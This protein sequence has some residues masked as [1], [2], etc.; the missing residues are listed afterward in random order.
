MRSKL[1]SVF[2]TETSL[3][4]LISP[5]VFFF[6]K[7]KKKNYVEFKESRGLAAVLGLGRS[8]YPE[9]ETSKLGH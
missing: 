5:K 6:V 9:E 4:M 2:K 8:V 3:L 7:K 1:I